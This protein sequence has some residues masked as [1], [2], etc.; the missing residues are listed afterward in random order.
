MNKILI[1]KTG[2]SE[3]LDKENNSRKV[4][5]GDILRTTCLLHLFKKDNVSWV[6]DESAFPL[7]EKNPYIH[8]VLPYD[9]TT[10]FQLMA[11][12]FDTVINLEKTP[13]ICALSDRIRARRNRY[14]FT[15]N[16]QSG[17]AEPY[18]MA[19]NILTVCA[20]PHL[21]KTNKKTAQELLFETVGETWNKEEYVL[22]YTPK[23]DEIFDVGLNTQV[24][25][26]WPTKSWP[27][28]HWDKLES[29]LSENKIKTSRQEKNNPLI[30][31]DLFKYIDWINSCKVLV[32][33]DSLGLH[34]G[35][36][37]KKKVFGLFG[38][39]PHL[40]VYFYGRG[41]AILPE[42]VPSCLPCF[43]GKCLRERNCLEDI[44]PNTIY[45][46]VLKII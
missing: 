39:T 36:A 12:E 42:P 18:A 26:K 25:Q 33:N 44:S 16:S 28:N 29:L 22:G 5:L 32:S 27:S 30:L 13:G 6:T 38:P 2:Y 41:K 35:I 40:E 10:T 21:K 37:L 20:D 23:T 17:T 46:E 3:L 15:F 31:G 45:N 7:L 11:E 43:E 1:I 24:G 34:L 19:S 9:L 8:R 14:G 4:S